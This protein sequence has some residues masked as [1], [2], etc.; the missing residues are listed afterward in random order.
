MTFYELNKR[1]YKL[2]EPTD[3]C[4]GCDAHYCETIPSLLTLEEVKHR[5]ELCNMLSIG[6]CLRNILKEVI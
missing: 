6:S 3:M 1:K 2:Q 4:E 5:M